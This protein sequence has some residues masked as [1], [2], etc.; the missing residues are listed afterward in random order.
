MDRIR[1]LVY[2]S[3]CAK[4]LDSHAI[5]ELLEQSRKKNSANAITGMLLFNNFFFLQLLEGGDGPVSDLFDVISKDSRHSHVTVLYN[6]LVPPEERVSGQWSMSYS[7][8]SSLSENLKLANMMCEWLKVEDAQTIFR[9][10]RDII[11]LLGEVA[12]DISKKAG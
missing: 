8:H 7:L 9:N 5:N 1:Q 11:G 12:S 10:R 4:E 3:Y 2:A 6:Q